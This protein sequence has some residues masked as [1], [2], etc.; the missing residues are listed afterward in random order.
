M[1]QNV[2][3]FVFPFSAIIGQDLLKRALILNAIDPSIGGVLIRGERG[4]AKSTAVRSLAALLPERTVVAGCAFGCEPSRPEEMCASC[5][6]KAELVPARTKMRVVE[7]PVSAT[8]DKVVGSLD[9]G[10]AI[11]SGEKCFEPGILAEANGNI[12]YVDEVNLLNDHIVDVLLD[13]AAMGV[14]IVEREGVSY[15]HP[16]SFILVGTMNPE[17]GD[18]RPQLLDRFGLCV[19]VE[20]IHD[21]DLR[22]EI[23]ERRMAYDA[24]P[25]AFIKDRATQESGLINSIVMAQR[26]L[27]DVTIPLEMLKLIV[28]I[29]IGACVD[30]HRADI[31]MMKTSKAIAAFEGRNEVIENDVR[32]AAVLVLAHRS[33]NPP[34]PQTP[35]QEDEQSSESD[36]EQKDDVERQQPPLSTS[37][38]EDPDTSDDQ[39]P[40]SS[41]TTQFKVG[42][43]FKLRASTF[44]TDLRI[45][46]IVR[47]GTGRRSDAESTTGRYVG[48]RIPQGRPSSIAIDATI[49]AAALHQKGR[50]GDMAIK[51]EPA[52]VREKVKERK[53]ENLIVFVV[54]ASGSMGAQQRMVAVKGA[55]SSLLT[56]AYQKRDRVSLVVFRGD[57]AEMVVPPTNSIVLAQR[58]MESIP[59]GGRTPLGPGL[60][61][62]YD[63]VMREKMQ[64]PKIKP[65]MA[66]ISDGR[67]NVGGPG[68]SPMEAV[69]SI[70]ARIADEGIDCL[71]I[72]SEVGAVALGFAK[73][74]AGRMDAK[75][76]KLEDL[77]ADTVSSAVWNMVES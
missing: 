35:P 74:L 69:N 8:E 16:S 65:I 60:T 25:D 45:D 42:E 51:I 3:S 31:A 62:A 61:M 56:D 64:N 24:N 10:S 73:K 19:N 68:Q 71:V 57:H 52:D 29:C 55:I 46:S 4:T 70:S 39:Q 63:I 37:E 30:G 59:T 15:T 75:Y 11:R 26:V 22:V 27:E 40:D 53:I 43:R 36:P 32:E 47:D 38:N 5:R 44:S 23:I 17:E 18:L 12:L 6:S 54:D 66:I 28:D 33:K 48:N 34:P 1:S 13:V 76:M 20:G 50:D 21:A 67:G 7:L 72:D 9:I 58:R 49:R 14:N 41:G 2:H 77:R